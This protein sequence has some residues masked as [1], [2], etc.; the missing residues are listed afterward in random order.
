MEVR[1]DTKC[2]GCSDDHP[3]IAAVSSGVRVWGCSKK[4]RTVAQTMMADDWAGFNT[5]EE[6]LQAQWST[7]VDYAMATGSP[8]GVAGLEKTV[9]T[10]ATCR[11]G[12]WRDVPVK[13]K[14]PKGSG[15]MDDLPEYIPQ[16]SYNEAYP[17][18]G[19]LRSIGGDRSHIQSK[20]GSDGRGL[21]TS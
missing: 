12:K 15:G 9:V 6:S 1:C 7:W 16:L 4:A 21:Q 18:M 19:I 2:G 3:A 8:I 10:A 11:N 14:V 13:L 5:T 17:H 20:L